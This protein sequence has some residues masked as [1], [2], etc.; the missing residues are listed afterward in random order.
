MFY[1]YGLFVKTVHIGDLT[2][3]VGEVKFI[4]PVPYDATKHNH[5]VNVDFTTS[6]ES[7]VF[8]Y[9]LILEGYY[10]QPFQPYY[11]F[12]TPEQ[13][14][15]LDE[16][17]LKNMLS[18]V[19]ITDYSIENTGIENLAIKPMVVKA[20]SSTS[21]IINRAG[22][23]YLFK[24]GE[25]IGPQVEMYQDEERKFDVENDFNRSYYRELTFV[26]PEGYKVSNLDALKMKVELLENNKPTCYFT[27]EYE[28]KDGK[29]YKVKVHEDYKSIYYPKERF[30]EYRKVINAAADFNKIVL[31]I[32]KK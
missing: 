31:V 24:I 20:T 2:N 15:D 27:S 4:E 32:E 21:T 19:T 17:I 1:N 22:N 16:F 13:K 14:K 9:E 23:K 18:G 7:P 5:I 26:L 11:S 3:Y 6:L 25:L 28:T 30:Q 8:K 10:A 29:T 12:V